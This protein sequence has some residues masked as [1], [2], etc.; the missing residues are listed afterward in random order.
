MKTKHIALLLLI[1]LSSLAWAQQMNVLPESAFITVGISGYVENPG[2]YKMLPVD[3][4]SDLMTLATATPESM[5]PEPVSQENDMDPKRLNPIPILRDEGAMFPNYK[6]FRSLRNI[7]IVR[8][9]EAQVYDL[10]AFYRMGDQSQN[11]YLRDSDQVH[12]PVIGSYISVNGSVGFPG[13]MEYREGD[14]LRKAVDLALGA[15][16]GADLSAVRLSIYNSADRSYQF[17]MLNLRAEPGMWDYVLKPGD[18]VMLPYDAQFRNK[19]AVTVSGEF[20]RSGEYIVAENTSLWDLIEL[21]G[22][23]SKEADVSNAVILNKDYNLEPDPEFERLKMRNMLELTP[24]EYSYLKIKLRQAK[25]RYSVNFRKLFET[26]GKEGNMLL[27]NGDFVHIPQKLDMVWVSGQVR[28]P[29]LI[30]FKEGAN[31]KY[32]VEQAG[33][34]LSNRN[35][36]GTRILRANSGNWVKASTKLEIRPG[37]VVMIPDNVD[38]HFWTDLKDFIGVTASA[39]TILIGVQNLTK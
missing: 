39:I 11:P 37:D 29:G 36:F 31:W 24:L 6:Q 27:R 17:R 9:G 26:E 14:T 32:Y 28:R 2:T 3:R 4:L 20:L 21:A 33:G 16:P 30:P 23:L 38:R 18:R 8:S 34:Y 10:L 5:L 35:R 13:D 19:I 1:L 25:G 7:R 12:V 22:G 15:L